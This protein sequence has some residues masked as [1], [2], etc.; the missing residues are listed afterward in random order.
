MFN[1]CENLY[2]NLIFP[3]Y[4]ELCKFR[5]I[6]VDSRYILKYGVLCIDTEQRSSANYEFNTLNRE[7][8]TILS[9]KTF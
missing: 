9:C 6:S 3:I 7:N 8:S 1:Y 2:R 4:G 5:W